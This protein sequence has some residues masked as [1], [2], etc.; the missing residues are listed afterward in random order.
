MVGIFG[1]EGVLREVLPRYEFRIEQL[2]MADFVMERLCD[3]ENGIVEA[4]TG[5]GKTLAYLI[6]AILYC[7]ENGKK[8]AVSTETKALQKQIIDKDIPLA[9]EVIQRLTGERFTFELCLGSGNYPCRRRFEALVAAGRFSTGQHGAVEKLQ[10]LFRS[11]RIFNRFDLSVDP[12]L[13][14]SVSREPEGCIFYRCPYQAECVFQSARRR[15]ADADLL[16]MN[17]YLFFTNITTGRTYL[18]QFDIVVFDEAHSIEDIAS[19][20]FGF[21]LSASQ[22]LESLGGLHRRN[23]RN[24]II[25]RL[26]SSSLRKRAAKVI[27]DIAEQLHSFFEKLRAE[28]LSS[29][30][31]VRLR[32]RIEFGD[33]LAQEMKQLFDLF[34]EVAEHIDDES[35]KMEFEILRGKLFMCFQNLTSAIYYEREHYVYWLERA[36]DALLSDIH[37]KGQPIDVADSLQREVNSFYQSVQYCSATMAVNGEFSFFENRLGLC[38]HRSLLLSSPF[39]YQKAVFYMSRDGREPGDPLYV[40]SA[41]KLAAHIINHLSGNCLLLFT[42]YRMLN[43]VRDRLGELIP[44]PIYAQGQHTAQE[45]LGRYIADDGS[46][47]MGTHSFWQGIDLPGDLLRG[48]ILMRLPFSV[49]DRPDVEAKMER[50]EQQGLSPFYHYQI[51]S[52]IIRF[53]QGF[54]RLIRSS[55]DR[56]VIAVLDS[57]ILTKPYGRLFIESIPQCRTVFTIEEMKNSDL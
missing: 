36:E 6:P 45:V 26:S 21:D 57:R 10:E 37:L 14:K 25:G 2:S 40:E 27:T 47:L 29:K 53:K 48:V 38:R 3:R 1:E 24:T 13:W 34:D 18:P 56:G 15:W 41:S 22:I 32:E 11:G 42:S 50:L 19:A 33:E 35:T 9:A 23:R 49:P 12:G 55:Q 17:H 54:G 8:L 39:D 52:A 28:Y 43:E 51:P 7:R 44:F 16:V 31:S 5:V 30:G 46:I 4:G 20:Q